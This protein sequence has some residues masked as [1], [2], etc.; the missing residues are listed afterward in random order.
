[1]R[2][3]TDIVIPIECQVQTKQQFKDQSVGFAAHAKVPGKAIVKPKP[4]PTSLKSRLKRKKA[5]LE[6]VECEDYLESTMR[7]SPVIFHIRTTQNDFDNHRTEVSYDNLY[8][9]YRKVVMTSEGSETPERHL[10]R[11]NNLKNLYDLR[12]YFFPKDKATK[13]LLYNEIPDLARDPVG[14]Q[15]FM[16]DVRQSA[17]QTMAKYV[18]NNNAEKKKT[19]FEDTECEQLEFQEKERDD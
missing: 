5:R 6:P 19:D 11:T 13:Y 18:D 8:N 10:A 4:I 16:G 15:K 7:I 2:T 9:R 3:G 14:Y 12:E 1:M 17:S